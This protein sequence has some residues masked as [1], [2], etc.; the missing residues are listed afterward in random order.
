MNVAAPAPAPVA[1]TA[2]QSPKSQNKVKLDW[3]GFIGLDQ[4]IKN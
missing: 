2:T 4:F 3:K 1:A